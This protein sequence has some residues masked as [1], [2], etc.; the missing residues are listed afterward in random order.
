MFLL[1]YTYVYSNGFC[2]VIQEILVVH[3]QRKVWAAGIARSSNLNC[4]FY[5]IS[6]YL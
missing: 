1:Y 5:M 3:E 6:Y 2:E 4:Y